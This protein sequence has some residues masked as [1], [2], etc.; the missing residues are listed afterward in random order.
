VQ[1]TWFQQS[2]AAILVCEG[3]V[4][5]C[6]DLD[7]ASYQTEVAVY[8]HVYLPQTSAKPLKKPFAHLMPSIRLVVEK[9]YSL[10]L[11]LL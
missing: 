1:T 6:S 9:A 10:V 2:L 3:F 5:N 8:L 4:A 11:A 7:G